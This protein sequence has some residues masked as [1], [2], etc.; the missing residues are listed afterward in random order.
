MRESEELI[1]DSIRLLTQEA[2]KFE[3]ADKSNY[4]NIKNGLRSALKGYFKTKTKRTPMI[5]PI[6]I[7]I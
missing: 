6:I 7:E 2:K 5:L 1:N 3:G 4:A